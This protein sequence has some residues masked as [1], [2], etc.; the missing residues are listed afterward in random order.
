[1]ISEY[2]ELVDWTLQR[3]CTLR[4]DMD[5]DDKGY[6]EFEFNTVFT[7]YTKG[8]PCPSDTNRRA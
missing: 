7:I 2:F 4:L 6:F 3:T 1:M 8:C 5:L